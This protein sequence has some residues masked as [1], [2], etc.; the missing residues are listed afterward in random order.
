[1]PSSQIVSTST[2]AQ[3]SAFGSGVLPFLID[4]VTARRRARPSRTHPRRAMI[5]AERASAS[6]AVCPHACAVQV[7]KRVLPDYCR[8]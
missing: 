8:P 3:R 4:V 7:L 6:E 2:I 1:M 5:G